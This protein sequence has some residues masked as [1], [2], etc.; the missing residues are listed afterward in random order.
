MHLWHST[1]IKEGNFAP[2]V[3]VI[4]KFVHYNDTRKMTWPRSHH[5][6]NVKIS[7]SKIGSPI[8]KYC[9]KKFQAL[10]PTLCS[11]KTEGVEAAEPTPGHILW[12]GKGTLEGDLNSGCYLNK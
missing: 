11:Y 5:M 6:H 1:E 12:H 2:M 3:L 10:C 4:I 9:V 8:H 7:S